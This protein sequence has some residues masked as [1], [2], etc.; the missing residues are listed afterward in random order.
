MAAATLGRKLAAGAALAWT[1]AGAH[2]GYLLHDELLCDENRRLCIRGWLI[3]DP[4]RNEIALDARLQR[5]ATPGTVTISLDGVT[6]GGQPVTT[7]VSVEVRGHY[8]EIIH[9]KIIPQW[10]FET[11]WVVRALR[12]EPA[13]LPA[14]P[15][16]DR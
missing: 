2:T 1:C 14:R 6:P 9:A 7:A 13:A 3:H 15:G 16:A 4:H 12:F 10:P 11:Q 5:T 8:S